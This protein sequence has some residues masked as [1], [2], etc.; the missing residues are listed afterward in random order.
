MASPTIP[1]PSTIKPK[2]SSNVAI[3]GAGAAGLTAARELR[4]EGHHVVV[5]E[6][7]SK[8]GGLWLYEPNTDSDPLGID[9]NRK[10]VQSSLYDSLRTNLPRESMG[11]QAYP[12]VETGLKDRDQRRYPGHKEVLDY[13][14]DYAKVFRVS[15]LVRFK[16]EVVRVRMVEGGKWEV[17]WRGLEKR[18]DV[19]EVFDAVVICNGHHTEPRLASIPGSDKWPGKQMHSHN[20][21]VP[22]PFRDQVVIL[23]GS[24]ASASDICRDIAGVAKEVHVAS[25]SVADQTFHILPGHENIWLHSMIRTAHQDGSVAFGNGRIVNADVIMH[26]T[27]YKYH[28]PF[29]E[30]NGIVTVDD[31]R[32]GPLYLHVFPPALAPSLSFVGLPLDVAPFPLCECQSKW[33]AGVLSGRISLPSM[34][35]MMESIKVFYT[36]LGASGIPK[37]YTHNM[38]TYQFEYNDWLAGQCGCPGIEE[39]RRQ[40]YY[41]S[42]KRQLA[43]PETFRDE[44]E[45]QEWILQAYEDFKQRAAND[46]TI[47][48]S[49][50]V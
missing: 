49:L 32:V 29:L 28:F 48:S 25:R 15:E 37:H 27:G 9:P 36:K 17:K 10:I 33:V 19:V 46:L 22:D 30:T 43:K 39:W 44:W 42:S 13:L 38:E 12:F 31:N 7:E 14:E 21:R 47:R 40:M 18:V 23:I 50:G 4:L 16:T 2:I 24:S 45:D 41:A 11:F 26:C 20:Y 5:F 6:R 34:E 1:N 8:I 35:K 3:V